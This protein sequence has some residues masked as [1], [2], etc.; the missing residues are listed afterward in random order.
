MSFIR[1]L[2]NLFI[3]IKEGEPHINLNFSMVNHAEEL[4]GKNIIVTGGSKGLGYAIAKKCVEEAANVLITGRNKE[5]LEIAKKS[6]EPHCFAVAF[7]ITD[8]EK[9]DTFYFEADRLFP[10]NRI[11]AI[12]NN[13]GISLHE[14]GIMN[15]TVDSWDKQIDINLKGTYFFT[16]GY[17]KYIEANKQEYGNILIVSSERG[18]SGDS[19]PYGLS[20]AAINNFVQGL[21][22]KYIERGIRVNGIAPGVTA[23]EMTGINVDGNLY[24]YDAI[25]KRYFIPDEVAEVAEFLLSDRSNCISGEVIACDQGQY[26]SNNWGV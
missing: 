15:V 19:I 13:A 3:Y 6:L 5:S 25:G 9:I 20:K 1:K 4:K 24:R 17:L 26:L 23:T 7:D 22:K 18:L 14:K 12:V 8:F 21:S 10:D 2:K 16:K 11:D